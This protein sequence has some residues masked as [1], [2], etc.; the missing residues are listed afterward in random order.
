MVQVMFL[1]FSNTKRQ[2]FGH[3]GPSPR[4]SQSLPIIKYFDI[5]KL[6]N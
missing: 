2:L 4:F 5:F 6:I 1:F 3:Q